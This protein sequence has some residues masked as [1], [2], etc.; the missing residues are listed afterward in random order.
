MKIH[1]KLLLAFV[2]IVVS[3]PTNALSRQSSDR[4]FIAST[5]KF[6]FYSNYWLNLHHYLFHLAK[7]TNTDE[8]YLSEHK[9]MLDMNQQES[10]V[11]LDAINYY[12]NQLIHKDLLF[13]QE[14]FNLK[15]LLSKKQMNESLDDMNHSEP[16]EKHLNSVSP[17][18]KKHF[19][20]QH[21]KQNHDTLNKHLK[22]IKNKETVFFQT[23]A[24]LSLQAWPE[25]RIRIDLSYHVSWSEAY[26]TVRPQIHAVISSFHYKNGHDFIELL[27]HESSHGIIAPNE[28]KVAEIIKKTSQELNIKPPRQLWHGIL[29]YLAGATTQ[30]ILAQEGI[31]YDLYMIR[32][33]IFSSQIPYLTQFMQPYVN[34]QITIEQAI[35][36]ILLAYQKDE[37]TDH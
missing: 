7:N 13:Y 30:Q 17:I 29:F 3:C 11:W 9:V 2:F 21:D 36:G 34:G 32:Q 23:L 18:Y 22:L 24:Q 20:P 28:F 31:E 19:W 12:R 16:L 6:D 10:K 5:E 14:M 26:T 35:E 4:D 33:Q 25:Q 27:W 15:L 8:T 37:E 1:F